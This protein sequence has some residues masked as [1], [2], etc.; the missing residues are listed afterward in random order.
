M[1]ATFAALLAGRGITGPEA[2]FEGTK[3]F[4]DTIAG[5]FQNV[6]FGS[7]ANCGFQATLERYLRICRSEWIDGV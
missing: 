5:P 3:G 1:A 4:K 7:L 6:F 2:V